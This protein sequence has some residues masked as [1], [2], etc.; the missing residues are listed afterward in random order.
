MKGTPLKTKHKTLLKRNGLIPE[1]YLLLKELNY[2]LFLIDVRNNTI[3]IV[4]KRS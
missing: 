2:T 3:K 1:N 4:N